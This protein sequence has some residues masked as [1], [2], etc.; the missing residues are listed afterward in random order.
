MYPIR[1]RKELQSTKIFKGMTAMKYLKVFVLDIQMHR[2]YHFS[3]KWLEEILQ[4]KTIKITSEV[5]IMH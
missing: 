4:K 5:I 3:Q 1:G 2:I